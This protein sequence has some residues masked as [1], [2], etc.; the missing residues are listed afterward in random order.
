MGKAKK[1]AAVMALLAALAVGKDSVKR[2]TPSRPAVQESTKRVEV[3]RP[4]FKNDEER[5]AYLAHFGLSPGPQIDLRD[6]VKTLGF[7]NMHLLKTR[8]S[9][10]AHFAYSVP[11]RVGESNE[12]VWR[13]GEKIVF[14][15]DGLRLEITLVKTT[16]NHA[17]FRH[18][19]T[20]RSLNF[21]GGKT[22]V[23]TTRGFFRVPLGKTTNLFTQLASDSK[24]GE[25]ADAVISGRITF[26]DSWHADLKEV[27][28]RNHALWRVGYTFT[29][30]WH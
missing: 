23:S 9:N 25:A 14:E 15:G 5:A 4:Q 26:P 10:A 7:V 29:R 1:L 19:S 2:E 8:G 6:L 18:C 11:G 30:E 21:P 27:L 24:G 13:K 28:S 3:V 16:K 12:F 22:S 17:F 20:V